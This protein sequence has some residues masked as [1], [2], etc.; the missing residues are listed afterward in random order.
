MA[1]VFDPHP[2]TVLAAARGPEAPQGPA[3]LSD[4]AQR[5]RWLLET[6]ADTVVRLDPCGELPGAPGKRLLDLTADEFID[7]TRRTHGVAGFVEGADFRFG[8]GRT[9][10]VETLRQACARTDGPMEV[11][12]PIEVELADGARMPARSGVI[13]ELVEQGRVADA[14]DVLGRP[15]EIEGT[16]EQ[17]DQRG[18]TIGFP[19]VNIRAPHLLPADGVYAGRAEYTDAAGARVVVTAAIS[20]GVK[21]T[22]AGVH[23]R[24]LEAHLIGVGGPGQ[25]LAGAEYGWPV[26]LTIHHWLRAQVKYNGLEELVRAINR[27]CERIVHLMDS[28]THTESGK[29]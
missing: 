27:D 17:G 13:R 6:G 19:T 21:P 1:M 20:V 5:Q 11:V 8:K 29:A 24:T 25:K 9:G 2:A 26:R 18:R 14:A 15:Y 22:F 28:E 12:A 23:R 7:W 10:T 4:F 3:L 16:A